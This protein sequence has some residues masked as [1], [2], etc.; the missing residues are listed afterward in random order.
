[1]TNPDPMRMRRVIEMALE[2][3]PGGIEIGVIQAHATGTPLGDAAEARAISEI[4]GTK[5]PVTALK[6]YLG[7]TLGAGGAIEVCLGLEMLASSQVF[8]IRHIGGLDEEC[9]KISIARDELS[10]SADAAIM[11]NTF[12]FGGVNTCIVIR[13]MTK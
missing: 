2:S 13:R 7:H 1:M 6:S 9:G 10:I 4:F 3:M 8:P 5:V 11:I 12:A